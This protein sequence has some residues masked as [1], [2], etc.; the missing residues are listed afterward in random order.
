[1]KR[2]G[3]HLFVAILVNALA[4]AGSMIAQSSNWTV[5]SSPSPSTTNFLYGVAA[6][7]ASD[8]W[9]VGYDYTGQTSTQ[10]TLTEHWNGSSWSVIPSPSP[11]NT[12]RCGSGVGYTGNVLTGVA[13]ISTTDAWAVGQVC[14]Y[15][16]S[17]TL[18]EHWNG[19]Q[20]VVVP[21]PN[22]PGPSTLAGVT[23]I[24]TNDTWA[25]GN[26]QVGSQYR[27]E[28][29][30][31]HWDGTK[32]GIIPSPN[33]ANAQKS[34]LIS[35]AALSATNV[36]AVGYSEDTTRAPYDLPLIEHYDGH[37]WTIVPSV[38]PRPSQYNSLYAIA[39]ISGSDIWAVGYANANSMGKNGAALI[40]HWDGTK[41]T[42][43]DSPIGGNAT[44]LYGIAALSSTN[45]WVVGYTTTS[46]IQYLP[47]TEQWNGTKWTIVAP[48]NPGKVAQLFSAS[49]A[50]GS[51]WAVGA[52]SLS[53]MTAGFMQ[54]P[55]TFAI[56]RK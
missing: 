41:W 6:V 20:W 56:Q 10:A 3:V 26:Y 28:T 9:G 53:K 4:T 36:W 39:A 12:T 43:A 48:P 30:I 31:E 40:E 45:I 14:G 33:A 32:W 2:Y 37:S 11:G 22:E 51:V 23:S 16:N 42:L 27:W 49:T 46:S 44:A 15:S 55:L 34:F 5:L 7:S 21:S 38:Y 1:M 52:Y 8:V 50:N 35:V 54:D 19:S 47:I 17:Q 29:L 24:S 18:T 13:A 25:V